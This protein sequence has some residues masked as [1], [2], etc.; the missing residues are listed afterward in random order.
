MTQLTSSQPHHQRQ[1][2]LKQNHFQQPRISLQAARKKPVTESVYFLHRVAILCHFMVLYLCLHFCSYYKTKKNPLVSN[3][4]NYVLFFTFL[5]FSIN[6]SK[7]NT[8]FIKILFC[9]STVLYCSQKKFSLNIIYFKTSF[10][11]CR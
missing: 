6:V 8:S 11:K 3:L 4:Y 1:I 9:H 7:T 2:F 10:E 5:F